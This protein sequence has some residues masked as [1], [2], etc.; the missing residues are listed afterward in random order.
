[1]GGWATLAQ[2]I[3]D[4]LFSSML[5]RVHRLLLSEPKGLVSC[6]VGWNGA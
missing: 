6:G 1:M 3:Y 4:G 5:K 2:E